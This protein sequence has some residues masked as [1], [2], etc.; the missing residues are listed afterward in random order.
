[1]PSQC[2]PRLIKNRVK[3]NIKKATTRHSTDAHAKHTD[4]PVGET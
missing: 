1:M 3:E 2:W 4:Y